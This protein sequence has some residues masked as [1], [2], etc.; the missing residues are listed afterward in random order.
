MRLK[1]FITLTLLSTVLPGITLARDLSLGEAV[2]MALRE[3]PDTQLARAVRDGREAMESAARSG[4]YPG[5]HGRIDY[6][7]T[8]N[9]MAG[10]GSILSQ[11]TFDGSI[12]F[13]DPGQLDALTGTVEANYRIYE[14][15]ARKARISAARH[16]REASEHQLAATEALLEDS[17][18]AAYF[19]IIQADEIIQSVEA[20]IGVLEENLRVSRIRETSGE[21]IRTERLN[22]EVELAA[23][24]RELLARRHQA[25]MAR[26]Q[27][28][29]LLGQDPATE[30]RLRE[31]DPTI[32]A[33]QSLR[34]LPLRTR[35]ELLAARASLDAA[36]EGIRVA[37]A[38]KRPRLDAYA[39]WQADKGWRRDGDGQ[40][41]TAGVVLNVPVFDGFRT[42]SAVDLARA[43]VRQAEE[44]LRRT[45]L[46]L[47]LELE[48]AR[49]ATELAREQRLVAE[50]QLRQADEAAQLSRERF[51]AGT[52]LST[53]L[54]GVE[55]R[56]IQSRIQLALASSEE[57][58]SVAHL[59]R[60]SGYQILE[61]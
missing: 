26:M 2:E 58:I 31:N 7:Q 60:V 27:M 47:Q 12:D 6:R 3:Q 45:E 44:V 59:R 46:S 49:L 11:G 36:A 15:G 14:G 39:A 4:S 55:N 38:G 1:Q 28:A 32:E 30:I 24:Q 9:S 34:D 57:Y 53:E 43:R 20:G 56:L 13:N 23:R 54:I 10:F 22:L 25:R 17:V 19:G 16:D 52:L 37:A 61:K 29:Y 40:S 5:V 50:K 42:R 18:V 51:A 35:P 33:L 8:N 48:E 21:L 41:W